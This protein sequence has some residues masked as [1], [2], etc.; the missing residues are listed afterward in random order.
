MASSPG[1]V[2][3][4]AALYEEVLVPTILGPA[5]RALVE[6]SGPRQGQRVLDTGCG[7][8]AAARLAAP[9]VGPAGEVVGVDRDPAMIEVARS[10]PPA[11]GAPITWLVAAAHRLPF[12]AASFDL[13]LGSQVLQFLR[14]RSAALGELVRLLRPGGRLALSLWTEPAESPYFHALVEALARHLGSEVAASLSAAFDLSNPDEMRALLMGAPIRD[15]ELRTLRLDLPLP[16]PDEF[17]PRHLAA[18]RVADD[19]EAAPEDARAAVVSEVRERLAE[20]E[21]DTGVRVPFRARIAL[22]VR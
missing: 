17:V 8:G 5:A 9:E 21:T 7:T 13:V 3:R 1:R 15:L 10:L 4:E 16:P 18:T 6:A 22:A 2:A 11:D 12:P 20:Y 19:F 14:H